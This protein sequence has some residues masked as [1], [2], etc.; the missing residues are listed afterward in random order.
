[1]RLPNQ[2]KWTLMPRMRRREIEPEIPEAGSVDQKE[3]TKYFI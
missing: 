3:K 2:N 1:M